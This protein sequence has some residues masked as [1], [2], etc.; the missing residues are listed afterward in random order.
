MLKI[1]NIDSLGIIAF[2]QMNIQLPGTL[3][4]LYYHLKI[5]N[6][7]LE[8]LKQAYPDKFVY[9]LG[10]YYLSLGGREF[11]AEVSNNNQHAC[12]QALLEIIE[13][14][15]IDHE[16]EPEAHEIVYRSTGELN[17]LLDPAQIDNL[18]INRIQAYVEQLSPNA[19]AFEKNRI[20]SLIVAFMC[21]LRKGDYLSDKSQTYLEQMY[22]NTTLP[23]EL[24]T[25]VRHFFLEDFLSL[26]VEG[27]LKENQL[28]NS[29]FFENIVHISKLDYQSIAGFDAG[30]AYEI[31]ISTYVSGIVSNGLLSYALIQGHDFLHRYAHAIVE[32]EKPQQPHREWAVS[33]H[34]HWLNEEEAATRPMFYQALQAAGQTQVYQHFEKKVL[35]WMLGLQSQTPLFMDT[36]NQFGETYFKQLSVSELQEAVKEALQKEN[37]MT[38]VL[39]A[40]RAVIATGFDLTWPVFLF[41]PY[42]SELELSAQKQ[43]LFIL[44]QK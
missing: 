38:F 6:G 13:H 33:F 19:S 3:E 24:R 31:P 9:L 44:K 4:Y 11:Q 10:L 16:Q 22:L 32:R 8:T 14:A 5:E 1:M 39:P 43:G 28:P 37:L 17:G 18:L 26:K 23:E 7:D 40:F 30:E 35:T 15:W 42:H 25:Q 2:S 21:H 29:A 36:Q 27:R 41:E 34:D 12:S 20:N